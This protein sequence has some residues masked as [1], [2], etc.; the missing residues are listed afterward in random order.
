MHCI[1]YSIDIPLVEPASTK[2]L[3]DISKEL[4]LGINPE[5]MKEY[6]GKFENQ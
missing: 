2:D 6:L 4:K 5:Q 3:E 1:L